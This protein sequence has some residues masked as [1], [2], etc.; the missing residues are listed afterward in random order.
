MGRKRNTGSPALGAELRRLRGSRTLAQIAELSRSKP[1]SDQIESISAPTLCQIESGKT[2]PTLDTMHALATVYRVNPQTLYDLIVQGR[3][4][5]RRPDLPE[6]AEELKRAYAGALA[7]RDWDLALALALK[8]ESRAETVEGQLLW[9]SNR[10][11]CI[12]KHGMRTEAIALLQECANDPA[13]PRRHLHQLYTNLARI[14]S[15]AGLHREAESAARH[16]V[17]F[18]PA[19]TS[20]SDAARLAIARCLPVLVQAAWGDE[21]LDRSLRDAL[22]RLERARE[23]LTPDEHALRLGVET[24]MAHCHWRLGNATLAA[25]RF[26]ELWEQAR[27]AESGAS[28]VAVWAAIGLGGI[29]RARSRPKAARTWFER[30]EARASE[31]NMHAQAFECALELL[32]LAQ[33]TAASQALVDRLR[34]KCE[35]LFPL[36]EERTP[37]TL[38]FARMQQGLA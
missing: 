3:I 38:R 16:A 15:I 26:T 27:E 36:V 24:A 1:F 4:A 17:D 37:S 23:A 5:E 35:R 28:A 34:R 25:T 33:E 10:A 29:H 30:A 32:T 21:S 7:D 19:H 14:Q 11:V 6:D 9:R 13:F 2:M 18:A 31:L 22:H 8:A 20:P 12:E